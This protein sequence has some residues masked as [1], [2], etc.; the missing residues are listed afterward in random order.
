MNQIASRDDIMELGTIMSIWAHPD[1]ET[2]TCAGLMAA[3]IKNGQ[4]VVCVTATKG[5]AGVQD[6]SRWPAEHL[7]SIR[8]EELNAALKVIGVT[9]H[10]WLGYADGGCKK[11]DEQAIDTIARLIETHQPKT[12]LT[13]G[14]DGMT[15]HPDHRAV[16]NWAIQAVQKTDVKPI[17][18]HAIQTRGQFEKSLK[19][20]DEKLNIYYNIDQPR[21]CEPTE[22]DICLDLDDELKSIKY[23]ALKV[24]PS[25]TEAML[26]AFSEELICASLS[27]E[28]FTRKP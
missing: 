13:F 5:E 9:N 21:L 3:A 25:Q 26:E 1:D 28:A 23:Q 18:Y 16:C 19:E 2:F 14:S 15:G 11:D 10:H 24:M 7:G 4:N 6:E 12:I 8:E 27:P 22:C 20:M 17:I